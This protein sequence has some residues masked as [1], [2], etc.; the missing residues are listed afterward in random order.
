MLPLSEKPGELFKLQMT[1]P[2][3]R[4][5]ATKSLGDGLQITFS[6]NYPGK[7]YVT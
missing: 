1:A 4:T 3:Y 2:H 5:S 6:K 7:I